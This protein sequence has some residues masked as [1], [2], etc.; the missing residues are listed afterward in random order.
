[1]S[2]TLSKLLI[3]ADALF[4]FYHGK[5]AKALKEIQ[6]IV[7]LYPRCDAAWSLRGKIFYSKDQYNEALRS[8]DKAIEINPNNAD[9]WITR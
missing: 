7:N 3:I 4:Y 2:D 9:A 5:I 6:K 1:M 8:C